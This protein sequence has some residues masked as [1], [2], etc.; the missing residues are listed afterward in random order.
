M[1]K[2]N[3]S[4]DDLL[5]ERVKAIT[6]TALEYADKRAQSIL[7][8]IRLEIKALPQPRPIEV[9]LGEIKRKLKSPAHP[10]LEKLLILSKVANKTN[11]K[12]PYLVGPAGC[13]KTT[14]ASQLADA[15]GLE[16]GHISLTA[17]ASETWLWGRQT[18]TGFSVGQF[19]H[20]YE[21]GGVFLFD[22]IDAADA[23]LLIALN[24]ALA[25]GS[26]YNPIEGRKISKHKDF[27][28]VA[29]GNTFGLGAD[30]VYTGRQRLDGATLDRF[31]AIKIDYIPEIEEIL[32]PDAEI[33]QVLVGA[34]EK[35]REMRSEYANTLTYRGLQTAYAYYNSGLKASE[36]LGI[37]TASWPEGLAGQVGLA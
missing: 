37:L 19:A 23:N 15:L 25:N 26:A 13:G 21:Y 27:Y 3:K 12:H 36:V 35:L 17:G 20:M 2:Q 34:R 33:R 18:P 6:D 22:E 31:A 1:P 4:I 10:A 16:Y 32:C 14:L 8:D 9:N 24:T 29:A 30:F 11:A 28:V 7:E 5:E